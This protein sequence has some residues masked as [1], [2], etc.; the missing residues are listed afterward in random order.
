MPQ[1]VATAEWDV[2]A[3]YAWLSGHQRQLPFVQKQAI[4]DIAKH[5]KN[6]SLPG[7]ARAAFD[8]PTRFT[9]T[10]ATWRIKYATKANLEALVYPEEKREPYLR[11]NI[12]GGQRGVKPFEAAFD[13]VGVGSSPADQFFPTKFA[14]RN[15]KGNVSRATLRKIIQ[16][17]ESGATGRLSYFIGKPK[18]STKPYGIYRRM[19][20]KIRPLYLPATRPLTYKAIYDI[21]AIADKVIARQYQGLF[22]KHLAK[23]IKN[24]K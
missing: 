4:N 3:I 6:R 12:T 11:A 1:V 16:D 19:A 14:R 20:A 8:Q 23:A 24:A 13:G 7:G 21:G 15:S 5:L 2:D 22:E 17:A 9:S 10:S 18:N